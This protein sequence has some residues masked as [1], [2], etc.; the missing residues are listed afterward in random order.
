MSCLDFYRLLW[1]NVAIG[2]GLF[3]V[4]IVSFG[5][6]RDLLIRGVGLLAGFV[7]GIGIV[8]IVGLMCWVMSGV[9]WVCVPYVV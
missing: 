7:Y 5:C 4:F 8:V 6:L 3:C 1:G 2:I 9:W